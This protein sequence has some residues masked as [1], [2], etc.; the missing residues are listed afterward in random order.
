[1]GWECGSLLEV[2]GKTLRAE[3]PLGWVSNEGEVLDGYVLWG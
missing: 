2:S 3:W 1:M